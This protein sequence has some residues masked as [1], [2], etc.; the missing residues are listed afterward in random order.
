MIHSSEDFIADESSQMKHDTY[1]KSVDLFDKPKG[2]GCSG[3]WLGDRP[4][5]WIQQSE[6]AVGVSP[7]GDKSCLFAGRARNT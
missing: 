6:A 5:K 1:R 3:R 2:K 4:G 7:A